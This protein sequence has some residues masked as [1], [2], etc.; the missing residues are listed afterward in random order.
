ME[1]FMLFSK[2]AHLLDYAALLLD[3]QAGMIIAPSGRYL[4]LERRKLDRSADC[5]G[6]L[7]DSNKTSLIERSISG[8]LLL[9]N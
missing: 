1:S 3:G 5:R 7:R 9:D 6:L 4:K 8:N 2:S